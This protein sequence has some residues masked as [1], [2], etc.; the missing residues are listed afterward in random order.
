MVFGWGAREGAGGDWGTP[1][2]GGVKYAAF[3]VCGCGRGHSGG[4]KCN[5]LSSQQWYVTLQV[6]AAEVP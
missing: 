6:R 5:A 3:G 1:G 4:Y 2:V